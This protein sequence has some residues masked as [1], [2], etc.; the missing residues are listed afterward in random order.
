MAHGFIFQNS[1]WKISLGETGPWSVKHSPVGG[2][3]CHEERQN[4][5]DQRVPEL[6]EEP[7]G[8]LVTLCQERL[9]L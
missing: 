6:G 4:R 9:R 8:L 3:L 7:V 1:F 5:L 2:G